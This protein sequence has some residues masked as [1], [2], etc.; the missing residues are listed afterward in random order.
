MTAHLPFT[1]RF[2]SK[3]AVG[4]PNECWLWTASRYTPTGCGAF[5]IRRPDGHFSP[6][7]AHRVAWELTN[8]SVPNGKVVCHTCI[9]THCCNPG[10]LFLG[11]FEELQQNTRDKGRFARVIM[12]DQVND[13]RREYLTMSAR[14][15]A[16]TRD[17]S[18]YAVAAV[19]SG[20]SHKH[21]KGDVPRRVGWQCVSPVVVK[22]ILDGKANGVPQRELAGEFGLH[23]STISLIINGKRKC[24]RHEQ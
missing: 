6:S 8:G 13:I 23:E 17:I 24:Y 18:V 1:Q 22:G 2:W 5:S 3:V 21:V 9:N 15:I 4:T 19:V 12:D 16:E 20:R 10:H 14:T 11:T 7:P